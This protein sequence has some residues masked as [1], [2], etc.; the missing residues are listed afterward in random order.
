MSS[1]EIISI[2]QKVKGSGL[3]ITRSQGSQPISVG[4]SYRCRMKTSPLEPKF[5]VVRLHG[6]LVD[7]C[8]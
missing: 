7:G 3:I 5:F 2:E 4:L 6:V 1:G 8:A